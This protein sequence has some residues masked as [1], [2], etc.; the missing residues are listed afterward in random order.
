MQVYWEAAL[1][2]VSSLAPRKEARVTMER[3]RDRDRETETGR[4]TERDR[5]TEREKERERALLSKC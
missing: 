2:W 1:R 3:G 5:Q 4:Q